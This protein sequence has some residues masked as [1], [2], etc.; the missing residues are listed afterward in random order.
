LRAA[1]QLDALDVV[2]LRFEEPAAAERHVVHVNA[3]AL[4]AADADQLAADAAHLQVEGG[5]LALGERYV[6]NGLQDVLAAVH[7]T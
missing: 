3:H 5:V 2:E 4:V 1:Q 7:A 6:R